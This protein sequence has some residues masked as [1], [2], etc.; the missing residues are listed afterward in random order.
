MV[1]NGIL[2]GLFEPP[3]RSLL[4]LSRPF[5]RIAWSLSIRNSFV[6]R[7]TLSFSCLKFKSPLLCRSTLLI[8]RVLSFLCCVS[9][10]F[11]LLSHNNCSY[12]ISLFPSLPN[13]NSNS[14]SPANFSSSDLKYP[15]EGEIR[16]IPAI[17][18]GN[19]ALGMF[20]VR[21]NDWSCS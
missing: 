14:S 7:N 17:F 20:H 13:S 4:S 1:A 11:P 9:P 3:L 19:Q 12:T 6:R 16:G 5:W 10:I 18:A 21:D 15:N 2:C 8:S